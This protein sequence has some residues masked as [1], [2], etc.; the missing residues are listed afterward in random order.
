MS[1]PNVTEEAAAHLRHAIS[2]LRGAKTSI[3]KGRNWL[4]RCALDLEIN[5]EVQRIRAAELRLMAIAR[6]LEETR[7]EALAPPPPE[8][9]AP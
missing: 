9:A 4:P 1:A 7:K 2:E 5:L 3:S 8:E 6:R